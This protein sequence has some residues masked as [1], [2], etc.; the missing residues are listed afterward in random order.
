M[1]LSENSGFSSEKIIHLF[2]GFSNF[3]KP[4]IL[5]YHQF[6]ETPR[7]DI[8]V[9]DDLYIPGARYGYTDIHHLLFFHI[10]WCGGRWAYLKGNYYWR[11]THVSLNHDY[12]KNGTFT[13]S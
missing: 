5:G 6:K 2:I 3:F 12:E 7:Y 13:Y 8:Y 9:S 11:Y 10:S 1:D 4:S